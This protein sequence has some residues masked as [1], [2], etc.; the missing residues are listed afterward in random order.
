MSKLNIPW[1]RTHEALLEQQI[2]SVRAQVKQHADRLAVYP[3]S[4]GDVDAHEFFT[5]LLNVLVS[6]RQP[7]TSRTQP[8]KRFT[9]EQLAERCTCGHNRSSHEADH[10]EC[11][12]TR[13]LPGCPC[14]TF[15][16]QS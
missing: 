7:V 16:V 8:I 13:P 14:K 1:T 10:G 5:G 6:M 2:M 4:V 3:G 12:H 9:R 11:L 15:T